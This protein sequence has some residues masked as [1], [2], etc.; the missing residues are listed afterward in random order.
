MAKPSMGEPPGGPR[1]Y[2]PTGICR[3]NL[4]KIGELE[5]NFLF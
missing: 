5:K 1:P 2:S 3:G 4:I